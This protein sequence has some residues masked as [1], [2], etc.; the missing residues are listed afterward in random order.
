MN[1][2][3]LDLSLSNTGVCIFDENENP[4]EVFSVK[5]DSKLSHALRLKTIADAFLDIRSKHK[6][7][8]III[9]KGFSRFNV[10]TQVVFMVHGIAQYIFCDYEQIY[11]APSTVKKIVS[12]KGNSDKKVLAGFVKEVYPSLVFKNEDESDAVAIGLAYFMGRDNGKS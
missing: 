9:E 7:D 6:I 1:I 2:I 11:I 4:V 5:T 12:G 3:A 10:S 8:K